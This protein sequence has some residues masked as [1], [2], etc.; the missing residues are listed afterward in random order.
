[1]DDYFS[2]YADEIDD[3]GNE[4]EGANYEEVEISGGKHDEEEKQE[5]EIKGDSNEHKG[6]AQ[7]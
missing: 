6:D 2:D 3:E 1:M 7:N 5:E 4:L